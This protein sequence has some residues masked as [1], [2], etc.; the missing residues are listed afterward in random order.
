MV[1][2]FLIWILL[3]SLI[4]LSL[5]AADKGR[6]QRGKWR[7]AEKTLYLFGLLGGAVGGIL[8]MRLCHHKTKH[9]SFWFV[10]ILG[11]LLHTALLV[12]FAIKGWW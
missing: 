7:I 3:L 4:T 8:G 1:R 10:N 12:L 9:P 5:Y 2:L 6:A 11:I